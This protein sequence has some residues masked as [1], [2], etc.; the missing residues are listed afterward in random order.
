MHIRSTLLVRD[1]KQ[2]VIHN[3]IDIS[4]VPRCMA[5]VGLAKAHPNYI[6]IVCTL[7]T[8]FGPPLIMYS[9]LLTL[10]MKNEGMAIYYLSGHRAP[11]CY[12]G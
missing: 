6:I 2:E 12:C 10:C 7:R 9:F 8:D 4:R 3:Y 1:S 5:S 11:L